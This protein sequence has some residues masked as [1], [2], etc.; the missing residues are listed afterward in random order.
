M[1]FTFFSIC[2]SDFKRGGE[3]LTL[4]VSDF[5]LP[6]K[7]KVHWGE[8]AC[9]GIE[10]K[11]VQTDDRIEIPPGWFSG[12]ESSK[13]DPRTG[14]YSGHKHWS[15]RKQSENC[16]SY[17][18][19]FSYYCTSCF[20]NWPVN[21][22][23]VLLLFSAGVWEKQCGVCCCLNQSMYSFCTKKNTRACF[24]FDK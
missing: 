8:W 9:T 15:F 14:V 20:S 6:N 18:R 7:S 11:K 19:L 10:R 24:I 23:L 22:F 21:E 12:K 1:P 16:L 5:Y 13:S 2:Y 4:D 3:N 17:L